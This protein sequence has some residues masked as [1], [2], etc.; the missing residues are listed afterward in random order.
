VTLIQKNA[1]QET[2]KKYKPRTETRRTP[3]NQT[4]RQAGGFHLR[5]VNKPPAFD[6]EVRSFGFFATEAPKKVRAKG[7]AEDCPEALAQL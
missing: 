1:Q 5:V 7:R 6:G 2:K 3:S 4:R